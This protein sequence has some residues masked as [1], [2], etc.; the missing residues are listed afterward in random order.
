MDLTISKLADQVGVSPDTLRYYQK[1]GLLPDPPRTSAGYRVFDADSVARVSFIRTAQGLGLRLKEVAQLLEVMD[2][3][4]CP[5]GH[6]ERLLVARMAEIDQEIQRLTVLRQAMSQTL[7]E[8]PEDCSDCWMCGIGPSSV[9]G[10][11]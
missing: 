11:C 6:A 3:G 2:K 10:D 7:S 8:C 4:L 1:I 9:G 5:C